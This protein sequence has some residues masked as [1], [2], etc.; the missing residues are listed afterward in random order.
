[1]LM[2]WSRRW[3][4]SQYPETRMLYIG[5]GNEVWNFG[6]FGFRR[7]THYADGIGAAILGESGNHNRIGY[8]ALTAR[9]ML[10][11]DAAFE[12]AG[13]DQT[14][15]HV[16][17]SQAANHY[18]TWQA[19][20]FARRHIEQEG[21]DWSDF[22]PRMGVSIASYWGGNWTDQMSVP[23]WQAIIASDPVGA[24]GKRADY[25][26]DG[27]AHI[28]GTRSW[29]L[30]Q[31]ERHNAQAEKFGLKV[32]GAYEGGSHDNRPARYPSDFTMTIFGAL[33]APG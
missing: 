18:G 21:R 26:I 24:A 32:I 16:I 17:E 12:R 10:A 15:I 11:L 7:Q 8:G 14:R 9:L 5:L 29:V 20:D 31:F 25:L 33:T 2:R 4:A 30:R 22:A 6:G 23:E 3:E 19:L 28:V 1:M 13:R 27:P